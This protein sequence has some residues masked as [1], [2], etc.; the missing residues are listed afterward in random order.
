M[1]RIFNDMYKR[2]FS[3]EEAL[4][5]TLLIIIGIIVMMTLGGVVAPL[6]WSLVFSFILQGLVNSLVRMNVS[7]RLSVYLTYLFFLSLMLLIILVLLPFTWGRLGLFIDELP[8]MMSQLRT[9]LLLLPE[10]YPDLFTEN[11]IQGWINSL[12]NALGQM[13]QSV[14]SYSVSSI[15]RLVTLLV[16]TI[17][18]PIMVFFMLKDA[19]KLLNWLENWLPEKRP[20]MAQIWQEMNGQLANYIRGKALEIVIVTVCSYVVFAV[21]GLNYSVLLAFMTGFSVIIPYVGATVVVIPV[22]LAALFQWGLGA[23]LNQVMLA[24]IVLQM[25]D[26]NLLVPL[27]F[28][29]TVKLHPLAIITAILFFGGIWGFWGVFFAIPLATF[30]K[31]IIRAWPV[32]E[33]TGDEA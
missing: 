33:N 8:N 9:S 11:Q 28:S 3:E 19:D 24:Y 2:Y 26:G 27:I 18:V 17:L 15:T 22:F 4:V 25:L 32:P 21:L 5:F 23:D 10:N 6:L 7:Y 31:A 14:L 29:E 13:G 16:Y 20:I 12:Q 30:I 1:L